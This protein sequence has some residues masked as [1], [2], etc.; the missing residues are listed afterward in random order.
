MLCAKASFCVLLIML[1]C[2][3]AYNLVLIISWVLD[4]NKC[5]TVVINVSIKLLS[6]LLLLLL[7][8]PS[9]L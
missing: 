9:M 5:I 4:D 6:F 8:N 1:S 7:F 2:A 3:A